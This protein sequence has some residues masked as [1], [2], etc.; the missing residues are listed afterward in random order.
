MADS[1]ITALASISTSTDPAVDPLVIVDVSDTS[2][3]AT[4]TTK[5]VTLNNLLSSS[6]TATGAFSVTGL[7]TAGSATITGAAT[8]GTT[9]GVTGVSTF[10]AG[11]ALL[12]ALTTTGDTNTGIYYPAAD[13]FAVTTAGVERY[14]VD[15]TGLGIGDAPA[16]NSRLTIGTTN[17]TGFQYA[18]RTTGIT[19]GRCQIYLNNTSGDFIGGIESSVA[20]T[21]I[22]GTAAYSSYVGTSTANPFYIVT[23]GSVKAT[24]DSSGNVGIGSTSPNSRLQIVGATDDALVQSYIR[25]SRKAYESSVMGASIS[26]SGGSVASQ[27]NLVFNTSDGTNAPAERVRINGDGNLSLATGN[28]VMG[29]SGKGIDFSATAGT[30]TSELLNDYEEGTF[31]PTVIGTT[32]AGTVTYARQLGRYIKV[33]NLVTVQIYLSW[34]GGTGTGNLAFG[35]LPFTIANNANEYATATIGVFDGIALTA[36]N[37]PSIAGSWNTTILNLNQFP[38]GGGTNTGVPYD[39][40][41]AIIMTSTYIA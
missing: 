39:A 4:G 23:N 7:V 16:T 3:A 8:V 30:G 17:A 27:N 35:G 32:T 34:S 13:T 25:F 18:I 28:L 21:S 24:V 9:L 40:A 19:T 2:M 29:T 5:K 36:L 14:R 38:V 12:P 31:L 37:V 26:A 15:S 1:K 20:G 41:G 11:T 33:G 22:T 10:A 6:P